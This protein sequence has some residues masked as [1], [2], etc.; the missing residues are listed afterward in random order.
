MTSPFA[1][2]TVLVT[3]AASGFGRRAA[4]RFAALGAR[5]VLA[6]IQAA[7]L[8]EIAKATDALF[9]AG[10]V[11]EPAHHAA[12]VALALDK[13]GRL[14]IALNNAG[15]VH[16]STKLVDLEPEVMRRMF[17]VNVMGVFL[18]MK[19]QIPA[20]ERGGG[21][22]IVNTASAAGLG[23][24]PLLGAYA[25]GKHAVVGLTRTAAVEVARKRIRV[26]A[27][28]PAFAETA[29]LA[30]SLDSMQGPKEESLS[31]L[32][33]LVPMRRPGT[34]DEIVEAMIFLANPDNS[35]MTGHALAVDGGLLAG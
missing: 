32:V 2:K 18:G 8:A 14:D 13:T 27:V 4:E 35:F 28:C 24:A 6:D 19:A 12:L 21:G 11:A 15:I 5:L 10:D 7:P 25:A 17:E 29:M 34:A 22:A 33:G 1:G 26:N 30:G 20:M 9:L 31:R 3:G 16:P 23:A